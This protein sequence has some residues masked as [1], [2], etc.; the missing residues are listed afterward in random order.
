[1]T[2]LRGMDAY[3]SGR[4]SLERQQSLAVHEVVSR[5]IPIVMA[6]MNAMQCNASCRFIIKSFVAQSMPL[7]SLIPVSRFCSC[8]GFSR[9]NIIACVLCKGPGLCL[10]S[11]SIQLLPELAFALCSFCSF[12]SEILWLALIVFRLIQNSGNACSQ[13]LCE[14]TLTLHLCPV[15]QL[16]PFK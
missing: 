15:L 14:R 5:S 13:Q 4:R 16:A 7:N 11:L 3:G 9:S 8:I 10:S 6:P 2:S 12:L 1:M